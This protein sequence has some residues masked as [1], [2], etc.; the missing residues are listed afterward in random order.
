MTGLILL[1][2]VFYFYLGWYILSM[3]RRT[4][5]VSL[6]RKW[7]IGIS[8]LLLGLYISSAFTYWRF[9]TTGP[10][11]PVIIWVTLCAL[12]STL[13]CT[14]VI[15]AVVPSSRLWSPKKYVYVLL[16]L[17]LLLAGLTMTGI[18]LSRSH[19]PRG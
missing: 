16:A 8:V 14:E 9:V 15:R 10:W 3:S 17:W 2:V 19:P 5:E 18:F 13:L 11:V 4:A 1:A 6:L 12:A 7:A